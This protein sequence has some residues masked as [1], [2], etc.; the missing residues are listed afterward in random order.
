MAH[1]QKMLDNLREGARAFL[2]L[3]QDKSELVVEE[4]L[5]RV[6]QMD[7]TKDEEDSVCSMIYAA[8]EAFTMKGNIS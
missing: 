8:E 1:A 4:L 2:A 5:D 7:L 6:R 3:R